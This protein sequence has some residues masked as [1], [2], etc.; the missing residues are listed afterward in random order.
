[1]LDDCVRLL[2]GQSLLVFIQVISSLCIGEHPGASVCE[3]HEVRTGLA[4]GERAASHKHKI[5]S[6][7]HG[8]DAAVS[9]CAQLSA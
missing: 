5:L 6:D 1:M 7:K 4:I 9:T 2:S 3:A 8:L